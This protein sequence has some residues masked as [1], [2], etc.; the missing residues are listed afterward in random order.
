M[1]DWAN[2]AF[3][4]TVIA[5]LFPIFFKDYW[6]KGT[7]ATESTF[8]LGV[9]VSVSSL[10][11]SVLSPILGALADL[12]SAKKRLLF[13]FASVSI[14][15]TGSFFLIGEGQWQL[16]IFTYALANVGFLSANTFYD[17]LLVEVSTPK[18]SDFVS[19]LGYALGYFGGGLLFLLNIIMIQNPASFGLSG[20][21]QAVQVSFLT[22]AIWWAVFSIPIFLFVPES[23]GNNDIAFTEAAKR[24]FSELRQSFH[25][26]RKLKTILLFL[27]AYWLYIDGVDTI[28]SMAV[29]YGKSIGIQNGDLITALLMVQ[30]VAF[31]F[32]LLFGYLGQKFNTKSMILVGIGAYV[33]VTFMGH[34][35]LAYRVFWSCL[36]AVFALDQLTKFWI[37]A[38]LAF[39]T[40]GEPG[41]IRVVRDF[42]YIVHV[43]NTGA[44]WSM[45]AGASLWLGLLALGTL[46]AIFH[47]RQQ[48]GLRSK[49]AQ[50]AFGLLC[51]G[52]VGNLVDRLAHGHVIDFLDFHFGAYTYPTFNVADIG[53]CV[54]VFWYVLWSLRQPTTAA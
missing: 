32:A 40:Y 54:G 26:I 42:F 8:W 50:G 34:R 1:Y 27:I 31:P 30:F 43:G 11:V 6:S 35:A 25:E 2:S 49:S 28:I 9:A 12:G 38:R 47:W 29:D 7:S 20:S 46:A 3:S 21:A 15:M 37:K 23:K 5:G 44:A 17:S 41:A 18:T 53:I 39:P 16:A 52:I 33:L 13:F 36:I 45:F 24:S 10:T 19:S 14:V 22:V 48:L 51:G 4:T